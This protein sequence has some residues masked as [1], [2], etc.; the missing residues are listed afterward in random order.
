MDPNII[1]AL[2]GVAFGSLA[3]VI[4]AIIANYFQYKIAQKQMHNEYGRQLYAKRLEA[5]S[6]L[7]ALISAFEKEIRRIDEKEISYEELENFHIEYSAQD[8]KTTLLFALRLANSSDAL[9]K[10]MR[11]ILKEHKPGE[12]LDRLLMEDIRRDFLTPVEVSMKN[13]LNTF[14]YE[15]P[16]EVSNVDN[17][18]PDLPTGD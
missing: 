4:L 1:S 9:I 17:Y 12:T 11:K 10:K 16:L 13:E 5:Y 6:K 14:K 18:L 3:T 15:S 2:I 8:S 7:S